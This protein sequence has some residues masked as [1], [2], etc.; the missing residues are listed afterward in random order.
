M[1][2]LKIAGRRS[3]NAP[4]QRLDL[5]QTLSHFIQ[6]KALLLAPNGG[7]AVT[8][9]HIMAMADL[10]QLTSLQAQY[11]L[12]TVQHDADLEEFAGLQ[13]AECALSEPLQT[14]MH[15]PAL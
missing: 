9:E 13:G 1:Q 11:T 4:L 8:Q 5:T 7:F 6:L 3:G 10:S 15:C 12:P 14:L 2:E